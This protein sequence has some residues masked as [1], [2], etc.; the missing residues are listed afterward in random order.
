M[1]SRSTP[2]APVADGAARDSAAAQ[3]PA[4]VLP[5]RASYRRLMVFVALVFGVALIGR[6]FSPDDW[7]AGLW[8]PPWTPP[9]WVFGPVWALLYVLI[10]LA[11]WM[12]FAQPGAATARVLWGVQL[13]LNASWSWLFFGLHSPWLA[14]LDIV[15]LNACVAGMGIAAYRLRPLI[16]WLLLPYLVW[17][18]YAFTLNA[19]I[20]WGTL[21]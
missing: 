12:I 11:G 16:G 17:V 15:A 19:A 14:L 9:G 21:Q 7:Y 1:S 3:T 4:N 20:A 18:T 10:A 2:A 13:V 6:Y 8:K 5:A